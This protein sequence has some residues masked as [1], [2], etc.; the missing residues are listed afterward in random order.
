VCLAGCRGR[1]VWP[2]RAGKGWNFEFDSKDRSEPG[3]QA[4]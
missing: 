3:R 4:T 1:R 2:E